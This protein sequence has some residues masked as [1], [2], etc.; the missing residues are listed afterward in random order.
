MTAR[1]AYLDDRARR[2]SA[3][4]ASG[5]WPISMARQRRTA[6]LEDARAPHGRSRGREERRSSAVH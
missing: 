3:S 5:A 4:G 1:G 2:R 6:D